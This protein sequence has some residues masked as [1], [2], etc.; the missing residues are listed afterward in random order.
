MNALLVKSG[1]RP[2]ARSSNRQGVAPQ[3][4][5]ACCTAPHHL[6]VHRLSS[7]DHLASRPRNLVRASGAQQRAKS[8]TGPVEYFYR[9]PSSWPTAQEI[10][11]KQHDLDKQ[12]NVDLIIAG[13]GPS[14]IVVAERVAQVGGRGP[15]SSFIHG[16]QHSNP[17]A[18]LPC[19]SSCDSC[20]LKCL[21][22]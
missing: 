1:G 19:G 10:Q 16:A 2:V 12:P 5:G 14:G 17:I 7:T 20:T 9:E 18:C 11:L 8:T 22:Y 15:H 21:R 13:A 3:P 4:I 6:L